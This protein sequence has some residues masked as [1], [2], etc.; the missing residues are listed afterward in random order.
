[1]LVTSGWVPLLTTRLVISGVIFMSSIFLPFAMPA[2]EIEAVAE[3][4]AETDGVET[5]GGTS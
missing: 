2:A 4:F 3:P 5:D 1:M